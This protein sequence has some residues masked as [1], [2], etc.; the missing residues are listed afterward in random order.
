MKQLH[1]VKNGMA[2]K[3]TNMLMHLMRQ[4]TKYLLY[5]FYQMVLMFI[6]AFY[7]V[8]SEFPCVCVCVRYVE[9][10]V[11]FCLHMPLSFENTIISTCIVTI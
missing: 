7:Y 10:F 11:L 1:I 3:K 2:S 9:L 8:L 4:T 6:Q 5:I